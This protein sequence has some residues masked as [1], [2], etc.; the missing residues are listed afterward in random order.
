[1]VRHFFEGEKLKGFKGS[2]G[3][4]QVMKVGSDCEASCDV[5]ASAAPGSSEQSRFSSIACEFRL[6][7]DVEVGVGDAMA[8]YGRPRRGWS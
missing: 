2:V 1:V 4:V 7:K 3:E 8:T 6:V 5:C